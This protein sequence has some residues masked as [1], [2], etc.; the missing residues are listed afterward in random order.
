MLFVMHMVTYKQW[1]G[2]CEAEQKCLN[3]FGSNVNLF[4]LEKICEICEIKKTCETQ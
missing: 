4:P 2:L 3:I 1:R